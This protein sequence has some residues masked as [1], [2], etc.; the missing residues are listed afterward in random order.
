LLPGSA[1]A[2]RKIKQHG[3]KAVVVTNQTGVARGYFP[4]SMVHK[5]NV[6]LKE[7]LAEA[8][9]SLDGIYYC[10]HHPEIGEGDY[11]KKCNCRK[12]APGM[13]KTAAREHDINLAHSFVIGDKI[14]D[15]YLAHNVGAKGIL[16]L[17]GWGRR[18]YEAHKAK[19]PKPPDYIAQDLSEAVDWIL[20]TI[21]DK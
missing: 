17:T 16:V 1:E 21:K 10:P 18:D 14:S 20:D 3:F 7:L 12:P 4:E 5:I 8:G 9:V 13:L 11:R 15:V 2:I 6:R 19:W